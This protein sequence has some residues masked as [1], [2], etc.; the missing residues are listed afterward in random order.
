MDRQEIE[1]QKRLAEVEKRAAEHRLKL[2]NDTWRIFQPDPTPRSAK[3]ADLITFI[4]CAVALLA[5]VAM[6]VALGV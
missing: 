3:R 1:H 5:V 6:Y 2:L 4:I